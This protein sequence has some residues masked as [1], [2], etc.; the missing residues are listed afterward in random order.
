MDGRQTDNPTTLKSQCLIALIFTYM[1]TAKPSIA[2]A[3]AATN[4]LAEWTYAE[5]L[6]VG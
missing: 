4:E 1:A 3:A 5:P 2:A 6:W